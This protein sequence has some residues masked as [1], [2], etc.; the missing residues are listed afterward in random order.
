M[1]KQ[2]QATSGTRPES[3]ASRDRILAAAIDEFTDHGLSGAR[4][5]RIATRAGANKQLIYHYFGSKQA[6]F[7]A[8]IAAMV[9]R[10]R[11]I[12]SRLPASVA[13][14]VTYYADAA[15]RDRGFVRLLAWEALEAGEDPVVRE[16]DRRAYFAERVAELADRQA[17]GE[18]PA[19]LDPAQL[20][21]AF[22]ALA[23]HP[24]AFPQMARHITGLDVSDPAFVRA[25]RR[26]LA[27]LA[28]RLLGPEA[29]EVTTG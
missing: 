10:F 27:T 14:R 28:G 9:D 24:Y 17:S 1:A 13:D 5:E 21:L 25:R 22:Q 6:L 11:V 12:A 26:F 15:A 16:E 23:A 19:D 8:A 4:V 7:D 2:A 29:D 18:L 20:F 3:A